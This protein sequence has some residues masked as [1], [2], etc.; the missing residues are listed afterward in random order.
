MSIIVESLC[1]PIEMQKVEIVERKGLGHPDTIC[2][3]IA[4]EISFN[5]C[6]EYIKKF[7]RI[8]HYNVDKSLLVA[9]AAEH[10]FGGG[11]ITLP[12]LLVIGDRATIEFD[13]KE[14]DIEKIVGNSVNKF[15]QKNFRFIKKENYRIQIELKKGSAELTDI[16]RRKA[17]VLGANDTS[18]CVGYAP[19][20]RTEKIVLSLEKF[21]NSKKFKKEYPEMGEDIKVMGIRNGNKISLTVAAPLIERYVKSEVDYFR[22]KREIQ[23]EME[24]YVKNYIEELTTK[25]MGKTKKMEMRYEIYFNTLDKPG[26][27]VNGCYLSITGTSAEDADCGEVGRGNRVNGVIPL[28][29]PVSAEAA[30]GKNPVSHIGKIYN[31]LTHKIANRIYEEVGGIEEVYVWLCSQIGKPINEPKISAVQLILNKG[32]LGEVEKE[33][34]EILEEE[35]EN[36]DK[37]CK[38]LIE[39][40][41]RLV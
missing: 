7:G 22:K 37:F 1:A 25:K 36:I 39:G 26:R 10:S 28:N 9:G 20:S 17:K 13:G 27:G 35:L 16:F 29:R 24:N 11:K 18:A 6:K 8:M 4:E 23:E 38:K 3:L 19:M 5:L 32:T 21:L 34:N 12:M 40:K 2:D 33:I 15:F 31:F 14:I 41:V 30:A